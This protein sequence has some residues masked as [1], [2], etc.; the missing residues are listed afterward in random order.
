MNPQIDRLQRASAR[1]RNVIGLAGGL[2]SPA[3][4]PRRELTRAFLRAVEMP[5]AAALQYGWPEGLASLREWIRRRLAARGLDVALDDVIVTSGAQ[6]AIAIAAQLATRRGQRIG[7][8]AESY[9]A[10]LDLFRTR[11]LRLVGAGAAAAWYAMPQVSN[12]RGAP[13]GTVERARVL[14]GEH[15]VLE[16]DAY[17]ELRF[18]GQLRRPLAADARDRVFHI[19]TFSKTLCPGLRIGWLVGP[20][21]LRARALRQKRDHDLQASTLSQAVLADWLAG[22]DYDAHL[23][24][25]RRAY[26]RRAEQLAHALRRWLPELRFSFPE[27][28][29]SIYCEAEQRGDDTRLLELALARGVSFDPGQ[30]F[31]VERDAPLALRLCYSLAD[32]G[33]LDE[34]V[35]RL[36][37]AWADYRRWARDR[38][39]A[40]LLRPCS[41][42][43]TSRRPADAT[44]SSSAAHATAPRRSSS[45][46][47]PAANGRRAPS[48]RSRSRRSAPRTPPS[49]SRGSPPPRTRRI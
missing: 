38:R 34:G 16:D 33:L 20:P 26:L 5:R 7:V 15:L 42:E 8:G 43:P 19:G 48:M 22:N 32:E 41:S 46:P 30:L 49:A 28:G 27:G 1:D 10:A 47:A 23:T 45:G 18:D 2:P 6:Q 37:R 14:D 3:L 4:F 17:A 29:F 24:R 21:R 39:S 12:P 44:A 35:R 40:R 31:R 13:L 11:G 36:A 9:P 25:L